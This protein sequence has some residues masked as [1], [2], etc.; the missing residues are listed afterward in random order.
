MKCNFKR[1]NFQKLDRCNKIRAILIKKISNREMSKIRLK[2]KKI[3]LYFEL[4]TVIIYLKIL[5]SV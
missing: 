3:A 2:I 1:L 4:N 5:F